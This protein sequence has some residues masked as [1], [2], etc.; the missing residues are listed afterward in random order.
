MT[1]EIITKNNRKFRRLKFPEKILSSDYL[2]FKGNKQN[3]M[4]L[5]RHIA[6]LMVHEIEK[7]LEIEGNG[8]YIGI[9]REEAN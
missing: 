7:F 3:T 4:T 8:D 1:D 6:G 5:I 9:F 2:S